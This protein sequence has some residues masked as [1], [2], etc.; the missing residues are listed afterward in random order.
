MFIHL[1]IYSNPR[2]INGGFRRLSKWRSCIS[3]PKEKRCYLRSRWGQKRPSTEFILLYLFP[4]IGRCICFFK[5]WSIWQTFYLSKSW[6]VCFFSFLQTRYKHKYADVYLYKGFLTFTTDL[7]RK[8]QPSAG[9]LNLI[10]NLLS[11]S[12]NYSMSD[13]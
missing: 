10:R 3:K 2:C 6:R 13:K 11:Y 5:K 7:I 12:Y 8:F 1:F 9:K 4:S